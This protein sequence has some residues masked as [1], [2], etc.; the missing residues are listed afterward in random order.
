MA[1]QVRRRSA[2]CSTCATDRALPRATTRT[3][4][5]PSTGWCRTPSAP[6]SPPNPAIPTMGCGAS[7]RRYGRTGATK[8]MPTVAPISMDYRHWFAGRCTSRA[9]ASFACGP[10]GSRMPW[11]CPCSCRCLSLSSCRTTSMS[12][13]VAAMSSAPAL[14]TT[15]LVSGPLIG[16]TASIPATVP[17]LHWG[18]TTWCASRPSRC[19]TSM[20]RC[21]RVSCVVSLF[22]RRSWRD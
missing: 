15:Q 4:S 16:C 2:V 22:W 6:G 10:G 9:S 21:A 18:S 13:A 12:K 19:C 17:I 11:R 8:P 14:N 20:S 1:G 7:C 5:R 3:P